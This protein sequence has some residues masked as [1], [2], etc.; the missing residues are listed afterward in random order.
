MQFSIYITFVLGLI[1]FAAADLGCD[2]QYCDCIRGGSSQGS[3]FNGH[4][5]NAFPPGSTVPS[6]N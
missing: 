1:G 4:C 6:C 3:C 2:A 5:S